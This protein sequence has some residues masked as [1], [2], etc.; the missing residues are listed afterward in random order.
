MD[1]KRF[2]PKFGAAGLKIS[3]LPSVLS[4]FRGIWRRLAP[5]ACAMQKVKS[6]GPLGVISGG[7]GLVLAL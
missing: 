6:F 1:K 5:E 2:C 4:T 7:V 3:S